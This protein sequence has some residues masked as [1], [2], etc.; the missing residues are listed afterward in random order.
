MQVLTFIGLI[1][2]GGLLNFVL[3][4]GAKI[5]YKLAVAYIFLA[6]LVSVCMWVFYF[7]GI[8]NAIILKIISFIMS[9]GGMLGHILL[10]YLLTNILL[11]IRSHQAGVDAQPLRQLIRVMLIAVSI[12]TGNVFII[13]T[14][15][16]ITNLGQMLDFFKHSG[17]AA[18]FFYFI[19]IAEPLG[20]LG[21]LFHFT[22]KTG[23]M[24]T[25]CLM[26][27]M[28]GAVYTHWHNKDPFSDSYAAVIQ[29]ITLSLLLV[30]YYSEKQATIKPKDTSIYII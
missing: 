11:A 4:P 25:A 6:L 8:K 21:I 9:W 26:F 22:L 16:K 30:L 27:L 19:M 18:W 13:A 24:A 2:L 1:I 3:K 14:A 17:Y 23:P 10:G 7:T 15:G 20:G 29:F 5:V 12:I 28:L